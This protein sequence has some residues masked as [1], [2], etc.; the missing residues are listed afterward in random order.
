MPDHFPD[1]DVNPTPDDIRDA[2]ET[3]SQLT[4]YL[5]G[6]PNLHTALALMEPLL[7]EY[8][9]LPIQLGDVLRAFARA[10]TNSPAPRSADFH[11]L[12]ADLR[13]AAW[14]QTEQHTL[15]YALDE[16]RAL[17]HQEPTTAQDRS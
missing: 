9:G 17:L 16:V 12:I 2:A 5:R 10:V 14:E 15:H 4:A 6:N 3:L 7:D 8:T 13:T 1:T 11:A